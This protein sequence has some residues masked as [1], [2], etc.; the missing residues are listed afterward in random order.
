MPSLGGHLPLLSGIDGISSS[1]LRLVLS[2]IFNVESSIPMA[3]DLF[4]VKRRPVLFIVWSCISAVAILVRFGH[5]VESILLKL[6]WSKICTVGVDWYYYG[7][8]VCAS[9]N[10]LL[11]NV[12]SSHGP[13]LYG[14]EPLTYYI[15]NLFLNLN[16][17]FVL[18]L[19][20]LPLLVR[21]LAYL[22]KKSINPMIYWF[23]DD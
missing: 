14:T 12:F 20:A 4:F 17:V 9:L 15:N 8:P 18:A 22:Q 19:V 5:S 11:Y 23:V 1:S 13:N 2:L 3:L 21:C 7:K 6:V 16:L 10:I